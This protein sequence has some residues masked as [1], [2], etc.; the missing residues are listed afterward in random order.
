MTV[1]QIARICHEIN[2]GYC[3][4]LGDLSHKS[5]GQAPAWQ[6]NSAKDGVRAIMA[7]PTITP[8]GSHERWMAHKIAEGWR[9]GEEKDPE[10]R[11]HPCIVPYDQLPVQQKLK[12]ELFVTTVKTLARLHARG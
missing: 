8:R 12:D 5:W 6:K 11:T 9:Y 2:R 10:A 3:R 1:D 4:A 7:D